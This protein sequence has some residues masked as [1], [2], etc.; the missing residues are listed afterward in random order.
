M[1]E[2]RLNTGHDPVSE[3]QEYR[4]DVFSDVTAISDT[5]KF[6]FGVVF[7]YLYFFLYSLVLQMVML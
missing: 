1:A 7:L 2:L 4:I 6:K 5:D 3:D